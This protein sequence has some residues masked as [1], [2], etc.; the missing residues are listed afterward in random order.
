MKKLSILGAAVLA[1]CLAYG[2]AFKDF[3]IEGGAIIAGNGTPGA[4]SLNLS[5]FD[6]AWNSSSIAWGDIRHFDG[7]P[8]YEQDI[9]QLRGK[10]LLPDKKS[11]AEVSQKL[12]LLKS[13]ASGSLYKLKYEIALPPEFK[14]HQIAFSASSPIGL[15]FDGGL[16]IDGKAFK[17]P[18]KKAKASYEAAG[19]KIFSF[20]ADNGILAIIPKSGNAS[21]QDN[22]A[23][24]MDSFSVRIVLPVENGKCSAEFD[25]K[26]EKYR[27]AKIPLPSPKPAPLQWLPKKPDFGKVK[28]FVDSPARAQIIAPGETLTLNLPPDSKYVYLLGAFS[29]NVSDTPAEAEIAKSDGTTVALKLSKKDCDGTLAE[30]PEAAVAWRAMQPDGKIHALYSSKIECGGA[31]SLKLKN[32][33]ESDWILYAATA[34]NANLAK[35][36]REGNFT[37]TWQSTCARGILQLR[38][39][40]IF[41]LNFPPR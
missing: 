7:S 25:V 1:A 5:I 8:S 33:G 23:W 20:F 36:L 16:Q 32:T 31:Q 2:K 10:L 11:R 40:I 37:A 38:T 30:S 17:L 14:A 9:Y 19:A 26:L 39:K 21:L 29:S 6:D 34:S 4:V 22:R 12:K 35:H 3:S 18:I 41:Q 13:D 24:N 27:F 28:Y 15:S